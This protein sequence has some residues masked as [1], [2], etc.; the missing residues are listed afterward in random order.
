MQLKVQRAKRPRTR[1]PQHTRGTAYASGWPHT[2]GA[3]RDFHENKIARLPYGP[4]RGPQNPELG[5]HARFDTCRR[6]T[7]VRG[8]PPRRTAEQQST[9]RS[10]T[11]FLGTQGVTAGGSAAA[12]RQQAAGSLVASLRSPAWPSPQRERFDRGGYCG[13]A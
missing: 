5:M 3:W 8:E 10:R 2:T 11:P 1:R 13:H 4:G 7:H 9:V 12:S 6:Q